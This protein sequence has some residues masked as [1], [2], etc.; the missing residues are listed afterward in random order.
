MN[1]VNNPC[2]SGYRLPTDAELE[3]ERLSWS[4]NNYVGAFAS[5]LKLLMAGVRN[6]DGSII[7]VGGSGHYQSSNIFGANS[8][9][10]LFGFA[11]ALMNENYRAYGLSVRC[12]KD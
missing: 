6:L 1:G 9:Y 12:I 4:P 11:G 7:Y 5:P 3:E 10:L 8:L 2:P